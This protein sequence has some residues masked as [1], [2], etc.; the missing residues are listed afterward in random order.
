ML[1][2]LLGLVWVAFLLPPYVAKRRERRVDSISSFRL[3][4][5]TLE[6]TSPVAR[7]TPPVAL[8]AV[9]VPAVTVRSPR[10]VPHGRRDARRRRRDILSVLVGAALITFFLALSLDR[11]A[12][13]F[14]VTADLLLAAYLFL[15][16]QV[17]KAAVERAV[18]VRYL[19]APAVAPEPGLLLPRSASN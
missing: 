8:R 14:H 9:P 10:P 5:H 1:L 16:V 2:V 12:I 17:R 6:R 19:P 11:S 15:L 18:K 7:R 3:H 13:V 4:L